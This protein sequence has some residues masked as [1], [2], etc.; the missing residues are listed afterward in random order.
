MVYSAENPDDLRLA[1][2]LST[3]PLHFVFHSAHM[4][5]TLIEAACEH[6]MRGLIVECGNH[7]D[8]QAVETA[9]QHIHSFLARHHLI[10]ESYRLPQKPPACVT[11]Y[12]S[13]QAIK[14]HADFT[15]L[16]EDIKTGTRLSKGQKYAKDDHGDHIAPQDCHVV[17]PSLVV[18]ATDDDARFLGRRTVVE[19]V[20]LKHLLSQ[21]RT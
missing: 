1:L 21:S 19:A 12:E 10:D 18:K 13:I 17:V 5:G 7:R 14:P 9:R 3:I 4:P 20:G 16:I 11:I 6:G 15:F 8:N 2:E